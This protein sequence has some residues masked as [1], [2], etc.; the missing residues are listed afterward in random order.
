MNGLYINLHEILNCVATC[1]I[2]DATFLIQ[3][4]TCPIL[5]E[6]IW[7]SVLN[8]KLNI[9]NNYYQSFMK[10]INFFGLNTDKRERLKLLEIVILILVAAGI[11]FLLTITLN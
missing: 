8:K 5:I 11:F 9:H 3:I 6:T 4:T 1:I 7:I 10:N 2:P